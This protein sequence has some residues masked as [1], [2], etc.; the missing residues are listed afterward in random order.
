[1]KRAIKGSRPFT[2]V[3]V[4]F[5]EFHTVGMRSKGDD[6]GYANCIKLN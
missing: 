5:G 6:P 1:M 4:H 2:H 3:N